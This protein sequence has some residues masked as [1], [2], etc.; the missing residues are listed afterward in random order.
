MG[1]FD[2]KKTQKKKFNRTRKGPLMH[3]G[4]M[5]AINNAATTKCDFDLS[6][7]KTTREIMG[8]TKQNLMKKVPT[9]DFLKIENKKFTD[10]FKKNLENFCVK[11]QNQKYIKFCVNFLSCANK[12]EKM[13]DLLYRMYV[14]KGTLKAKP[15]KS[16]E[17][18]T[19]KKDKD[20]SD[21]VNF[22]GTKYKLTPT[23]KALYKK[24][25][26]ELILESPVDAMNYTAD[27]F[28]KYYEAENIK[29]VSKFIINVIKKSIVSY[30]KTKK[31][32]P[33]EKS[34]I[35]MKD[36]LQKLFTSL[37]GEK[38]EFD[39][40]TQEK[41]EEI[42]TKNKDTI[43]QYT[44]NRLMKTVSQ[45]LVDDDKEVKKSPFYMFVVFGAFIIAIILESGFMEAPPGLE[46]G[47]S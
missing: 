20:D 22:G 12:P 8:W 5:Q 1:R 9:S 7:S 17:K 26:N 41:M 13:Y 33:G 35:V 34:E 28:I 30:E 31:P 39:K 19:D 4:M 16:T 43:E 11:N 10:I 24:R 32:P 15:E 40:I 36:K 6:Y 46:G 44:D 21:M 37:F 47:M 18:D 14:F 29:N 3:G 42:F 25:Q 45:E 2:S 27:D 38:F 23:L